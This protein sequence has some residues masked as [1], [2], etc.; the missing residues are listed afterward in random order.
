MNS[1]I[2]IVDNFLDKNDL[3]KIHSCLEDMRWRLQKSN[4]DKE[5]LTFLF[6]EKTDDPFF[7]SYL[8]D[9][10][11]E[12]L[13]GDNYTLSPHMAHFVWQSKEICITFCDINT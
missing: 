8:Y 4:P 10:V 12:Q 2:K 3:V 9:K 6:S 1:E 5:E 7:N 13:D 11:V